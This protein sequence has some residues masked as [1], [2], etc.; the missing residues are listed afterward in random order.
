M[1]KIVFLP[2]LL[3]LVFQVFAQDE[4]NTAVD[5]PV[6]LYS[7]CGEMAL[8]SIDLGTATPSTTAPDPTCGSFSSGTSND[9]WYSFT[10][11]AGVNTMAFHAFNSDVVPMLNSSQT[12]MAVY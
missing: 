2:V 6:E 9:L 12:A 3:F 4:C 5:L 11:P 10:V 1:K 7:T 8:Q